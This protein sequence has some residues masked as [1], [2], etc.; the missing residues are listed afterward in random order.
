MQVSMVLAMS[1]VHYTK[2]TQESAFDRI[3]AHQQE[4]STMTD[5]VAWLQNGRSD[6]VVLQ[7]TSVFNRN[8]FITVCSNVN[9]MTPGKLK[10]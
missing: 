4:P 7:T 1:K 5:T 2:G 6:N 8:E 10:R 9:L 3:D